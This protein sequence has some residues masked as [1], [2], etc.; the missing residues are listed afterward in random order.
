MG[1]FVLHPMKF[2]TLTDLS[3]QKIE[4][5]QKKKQ[6]PDGPEKGLQSLKIHVDQGCEESA[7]G[8][9]ALQKVIMLPG[10]LKL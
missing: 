4:R 3:H 8:V 7:L 6:L 9:T 2:H 10:N 1:Y 5:Y